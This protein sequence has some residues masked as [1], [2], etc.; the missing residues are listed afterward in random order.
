MTVPFVHVV[1]AA[2]RLILAGQARGAA[3]ELRELGARRLVAP[4]DAGQEAQ[5]LR[6]DLA[7]GRTR[8]VRHAPQPL[9]LGAVVRD[10]LRH[11]L[12]PHRRGVVGLG[13]LRRS[14]ALPAEPHGH[15]D[16]RGGQIHLHFF[17]DTTS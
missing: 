14:A 17:H 8:A 5:T 13:E 6:A 12:L 1:L 4:L 10:E 11:P 7:E 15:R 9:E 3:L 2:P 16:H